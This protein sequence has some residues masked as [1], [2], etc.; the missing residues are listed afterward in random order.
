MR[1]RWWAVLPVAAVV[2]VW[3]VG[4][5][6]STSPTDRQDYRK[7]A[8]RSAQSAYNAVGTA[9]LAGRA[10]L[11]GR[12]PGPYVT[13][14]LDDARAALAGAA[15]RFAGTAPP[16]EPSA[17]LQ[18]RLHPLLTSADVALGRLERATEEGDTAATRAAVDALE[19]VAAG[20]SGF[21]EEH[22]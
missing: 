19:P 21:V 7:T 13:S 12:L 8:V 15:K 9:R 10:R 4:G 5:Y 11:D 17:A 3:G 2:A 18:A 1:A 14:T 20:L 22:R 6:L 16:D